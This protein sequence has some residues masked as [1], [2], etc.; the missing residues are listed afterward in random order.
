MQINGN[1]SNAVATK[2][3]DEMGQDRPPTDGNHR[4]WHPERERTEPLA[5]ARGKE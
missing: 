5:L 3:T 2:Q 1:L 4:L